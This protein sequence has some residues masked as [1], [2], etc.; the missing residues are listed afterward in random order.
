MSVIS[1]QT[2]GEIPA[3]VPGIILFKKT[4]KLVVEFNFYN[5]SV[6]KHVTKHE[7]CS[8]VDKQ[9]ENVA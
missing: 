9:Q 3:G 5:K 7:V 2:I 6:E 4:K 1:N 8:I